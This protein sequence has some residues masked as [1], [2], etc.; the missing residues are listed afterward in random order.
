MIYQNKYNIFCNM[1]IFFSLLLIVL[2][3][4]CVN[5]IGAANLATSVVTPTSVMLG[6]ADYGLEENTGKTSKEHALSF[7]M[8]KDCKIDLRTLTL[9]NEDI[10]TKKRKIILIQND[11]K[12]IFRIHN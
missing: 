3:N 7:L 4:S 9:C 6:A 12:N 10:G 5:L 11:I 2:L 1:K 8:S